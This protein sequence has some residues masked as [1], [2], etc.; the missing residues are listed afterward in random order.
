MHH[1]KLRLASLIR[2]ELAILF[3]RELE[4]P[5]GCLVTVTEVELDEPLAH[6]T[7]M[8]SVL[9]E[10]EAEA[11]RKQLGAEA[12]RLEWTLLKK[13][14]LRVFPHLRFEIDH[15]PERAAKVE[16]ILLDE[17]NKEA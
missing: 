16:K 3:L 12:K 4:F 11:V 1:R 17:D 10:K 6:A 5:A 8:I 7:V 2:D 13:L 9:P 15:G 14:S